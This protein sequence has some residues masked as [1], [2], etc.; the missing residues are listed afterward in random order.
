[1]RKTFVRSFV[2]MFLAVFSACGP[3]Q[4]EEAKPAGAPVECGLLLEVG[5]ITVT[6]ADLDH[7]LKVNF[8]GRTDETS[9]REAIAG[10]SH[11]ARMVQAA[12]DGKL[13]DDPAVRAELARVLANRLKEKDLIPGLKAAAAEEIPE[14]TLRQ[15]Y[16]AN[17]SRFQSSEKRQ[18]AVLWLNPNNDPEREKQYIAKL[19]GAREWFFQN[20][21]LKDDPGQG[22]STLGIDHSE[23]QA[24]RYHNGVVGWMEAA[25]GIDAWSK[26]VAEIL[27][28]LS[29][30]GDVSEVITRPEGVFLVRYMASQPAVVRPFE[31]VSAELARSEKQRVRKALESAFNRKLEQQYP[32]KH[33]QP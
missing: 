4:G 10:I 13:H 11:R 22:F 9:R 26:A 28:S 19:T 31:S 33:L 2:L 15:L 17:Q 6:E 8:G 16:T 5:S 32:V 12:L 27:F 7:E 30:P 25:G 21:G 3:K 1:M 29:Q 18:V 23:H 14:A 20:E 24:S